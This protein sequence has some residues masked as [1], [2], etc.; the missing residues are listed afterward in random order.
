MKE[1]ESGVS[2]CR[3]FGGCLFRFR[4]KAEM[5]RVGEEISKEMSDDADACAQ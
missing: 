5:K 3:N 1:A 2:L 4:K